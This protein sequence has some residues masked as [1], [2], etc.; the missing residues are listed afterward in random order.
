MYISGRPLVPVLQV[1]NVATYVQCS[2]CSSYNYIFTD[3]RKVKN[4]QINLAVVNAKI[5]DGAA[6]ASSNA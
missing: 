2:I 4:Q 6:V 5:F 3:T 1:L